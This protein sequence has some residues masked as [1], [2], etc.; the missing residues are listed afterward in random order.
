[1]DNPPDCLVSATAVH[2]RA[3]ASTLSDDHRRELAATGGLSPRAALDM[4]MANSVEAYAYVDRSGQPIFMM[5]VEAA[6]PL[7]GAALVWMLASG[8]AGKHPRGIFRAARWGLA[9]AFAVTGASWLEQYIPVW[10]R[11]GL[12]F[13]H[14][15]GFYLLPD[16]AVGRDGSPM[17]RVILYPRKESSQWER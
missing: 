14:R 4:S 6:S 12:Q 1:M 8:A 10:Y 15:L 7:T 13:V 5:G 9:R 11:T 3:L 16:E 17:C 2:A